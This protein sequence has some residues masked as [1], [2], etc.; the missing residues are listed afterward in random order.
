MLKTN[1]FGVAKKINRPLL[2]DG[3]MGSLLEKRKIINNDL[4]WSTTANT[5]QPEAVL[6][7]HKEYI[8]A[9][10]DII[11]TNTFRTN[12]YTLWQKGISNYKRY[13]K[14]AVG[15]TIAAAADKQILIAG[16]N[17]PAE[18]CYQASRTISQKKLELNHCKHI[19]LLNDNAIHFILNETLSHLDEIKII[20]DF[21]S[22]N[23]I[24]YVISLYVTDQLRILSGQS[25]QEV[26]K[27]IIDYEPMAV[28]YNC[29]NNNVFEKIYKRIDRKIIW[30]AYLNCFNPKLKN[31]ISSK[32]VSAESY[33]KQFKR[34]LAKSPSFIGSCCGSTPQFT[35]SLRKLI[36]ENT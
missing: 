20:C 16:S 22:K 14:A 29:V 3:A 34:Y 8:A 15:L 13:V 18:D 10:A 17:P 6:K 9:G 1:V 4:M 33:A 23:E 36:N 32:Y 24:Q 30:G 26:M 28:A 35:R 21:C 5:S 31:R 11:T 19:E 27:L 2:L 7:I 12:P 25:I